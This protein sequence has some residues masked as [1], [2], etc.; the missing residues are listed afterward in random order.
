M[1]NQRALSLAVSFCVY[2][3]L[4]QDLSSRVQSA[5]DAG[6]EFRA[7]GASLTSGATEAPVEFCGPGSTAVVTAEINAT[8]RIS[9]HDTASRWSDPATW[10]G[11]VPQATTK[12]VI[13]EGKTV[14][15]DIDTPNLAS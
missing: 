4:A 8:R 10:G 7:E 3:G 14:V 12:V 5:S 15:L 13:P 9:R 11:T 1:K 6:G 2:I